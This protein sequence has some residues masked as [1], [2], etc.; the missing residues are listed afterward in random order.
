MGINHIKLEEVE[1]TQTWLKENV[2][3]YLEDNLLVSTKIQNNGIGRLGNKWDQLGKSI[4]FSFSLE[5][6]DTVTLTPLELGVHIVNFFKK[7]DV[8]IKLKWPNDLLVFSE[9]ELKKVGGILCHFQDNKLL[10][11]IGLNLDDKAL[12]QNSGFKFEPGSIQTSLLNAGDFYHQVPKDI[13][14]YILENRIPEEKLTE[15][16][17]LNCAHINQKVKIADDSNSSEGLFV[18]IGSNG[19]AILNTNGK[20]KSLV[21]GSLWILD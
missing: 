20:T 12:P 11:G 2:S 19:E 8:E 7:V 17:N 21:S 5:P 4:A 18:G 1:S 3:K 9:G 13:Y 10:V 16:W 6:L 14:E 15:L